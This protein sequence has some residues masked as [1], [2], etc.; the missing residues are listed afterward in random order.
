MCRV[1]R[2]H[3]QP[4]AGM[5]PILDAAPHHEEPAR[6]FLQAKRVNRQALCLYPPE[7]NP[8]LSINP[9]PNVALFISPQEITPILSIPSELTTMKALVLAED[10]HVVG[11]AYP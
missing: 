2:H 1:M 7:E 9:A 4:A 6:Q 11:T 10:Q 8:Y 5:A 3:R